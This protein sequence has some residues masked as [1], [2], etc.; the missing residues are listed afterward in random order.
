[1]TSNAPSLRL[2]PLACALRRA[3]GRLTLG[4]LLALSGSIFAATAPTWDCRVAAD[5]RSWSCSGEGV[6]PGDPAP[7]APETPDTPADV[8]PP[9]E[10]PATPAPAPSVEQ[11][12]AA[13]GEPLRAPAT[14]DDDV[15]RT[16]Q[17]PASPPQPAT[18]LDTPPASIAAEAAALQAALRAASEVTEKPA[19]TP[20]HPP[21][22]QTRLL[23]RHRRRPSCNRTGQ[24]ARLPPRARPRRAARRRLQQK[25]P[26]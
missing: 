1:M 19:D 24:A 20:D 14:V 15:R 13:S 4:A 16:T 6:P 8:A 12:A 3:R 7:A 18:A 10:L 17:R 9:R 22:P 26:Q 11:P 23:Q 21:H 2:S 25:Q 5:G